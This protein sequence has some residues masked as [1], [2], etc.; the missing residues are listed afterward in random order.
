VQ[1]Y[2]FTLINVNYNIINVILTIIYNSITIINDRIYIFLHCN[3]KI[4]EVTTNIFS[5]L[6]NLLINERKDIV[7]IYFYAIL[8]GLVEL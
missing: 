8:A 5:K 3:I 1:R 7:S 2:I 4:M 6:N